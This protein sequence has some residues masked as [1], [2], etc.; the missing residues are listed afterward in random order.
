MGVLSP[1]LTQNAEHLFKSEMPLA[2]S[3]CACV[4][5]QK[6]QEQKSGATCWH[7]VPWFFLMFSHQTASYKMLTGVSVAL[8]VS[9]WVLRA[10]SVSPPLRT[11]GPF[12]SCHPDTSAVSPVYACGHDAGK[13]EVLNKCTPKGTSKEGEMGHG[14]QLL[15]SFSSRA[16]CAGKPRKSCTWCFC[17]LST[18]KQQ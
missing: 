8:G 14:P 13:C 16:G 5:M 3:V 6:F 1:A 10:V 12:R 7:S 18:N 15:A 4:D 11:S 17:C 9:G 2:W